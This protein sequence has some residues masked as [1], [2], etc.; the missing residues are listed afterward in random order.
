MIIYQVYNS[1]ATMNKD[2]LRSD[3]RTTPAQ[4]KRISIQEYKVTTP[5]GGYYI[6]VL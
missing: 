3:T 5:T 2:G 6:L 1:N 4:E